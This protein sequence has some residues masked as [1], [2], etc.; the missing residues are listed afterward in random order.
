MSTLPQLASDV[1]H[2]LSRFHS[3]L[4][5]GESAA[6]DPSDSEHKSVI[7]VALSAAGRTQ[8][9]YPSL[10][11]GLGSRADSQPDHVQLADAGPDSAGR[12]SALAWVASNRDTLYSGGSLFAFDGD[13]GELLGFGANSD[14]GTGM[15]RVSTQTANAKPA[16]SSLKLLSISH[17]VGHDGSIRFTARADRRGV[18]GGAN[19]PVVNVT[20]PVIT[21]A[22]HTN[23]VIALGRDSQHPGPDPDYTFTEPTNLNTPYLIVPFVG[24]AKLAY[25]INGTAGEPIPGAGLSTY[26]YFVTSGVT[27]TI[28]LNTQYTPSNRLQ[29]GVIVNEFDNNVVQWSYPADGQSYNNTTSLVYN[30]QSLVNETISYFLFQFQIP[31]LN[32]PYTTYPF[33]VCSVDTPNQP[34]VYCKPI[35]NLMF[36]WHCLAEGTVVSLADGGSAPIESLDNTHRVKTGSYEGQLAVEA[37][38]RGTHEGKQ[39]HAGP[40][41]V[42]HLRTSD[43]RELVATGAHPIMTPQ[44]LTPI[45]DLSAGQAVVVE[46]GTAT[47]ASCEAI[48]YSGNFYDLKLGDQQD[49]A[50]GFHGSYGTYVANGI[51]VGDHD[52]MNVY[53][54][55]LRRNL[56]Y[57]QAR[58]P[59]AL[60]TDSARALEDVRY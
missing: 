47:V 26:L 60:H 15:L 50:S 35:N 16:K 36:W 13:S 57:M 42:Y 59:P 43:G 52:A 19:D 54:R 29:K 10:H 49:R 39:S 3:S 20:E 38:L 11:A 37:T 44:G 45:A 51:V 9:R 53:K 24:E 6:L 58:M 30:A 40:N 17:T 21:Q 56:D 34:S 25:Q 5:D 14:L 33:S 46:G 28:N 18:V 1:L 12:A 48:D 23:V 32:A 4:P 31:V 55:G 8:D 7:H 27:N 41:A 2:L 22:G